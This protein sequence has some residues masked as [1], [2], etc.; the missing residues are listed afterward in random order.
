MGG[1][2]GVYTEKYEHCWLAKMAVY[3]TDTLELSYNRRHYG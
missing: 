2:K 3:I 1:E